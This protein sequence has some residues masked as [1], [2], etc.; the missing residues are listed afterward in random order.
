MRLIG[1]A[2]V[3][4]V[5]L[6]FARL[7][8]VLPAAHA[9]D[10][11]S[12]E[13]RMTTRVAEN[14]V[15]CHSAILGRYDLLPPRWWDLYGDDFNIVGHVESRATKTAGWLLLDIWCQFASDGTILAIH[16]KTRR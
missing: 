12:P 6:S 14:T 7:A 16:V 9:Q 11:P 4:A 10:F 2:V 15:R 1:R 13:M 8:L 3:L 5:G